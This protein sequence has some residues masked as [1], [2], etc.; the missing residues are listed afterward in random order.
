MR[1][2]GSL[3]IRPCGVSFLAAGLFFVGVAN[4]A[5][6][7]RYVAVIEEYRDGKLQPSSAMSAQVVTGLSK[8]GVIFVHFVFTSSGRQT[9]V[10]CIATPVRRR[11][12][13]DMLN[14]DSG[15]F[16]YCST[17]FSNGNT[18]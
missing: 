16:L 5:T 14:R 10:R 17:K 7:Q 4:A 9:T 13:S 6:P 8:H 2:T 18:A 12:N 11:Y 1:K 3:G 15:V